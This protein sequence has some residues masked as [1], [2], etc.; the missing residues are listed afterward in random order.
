VTNPGFIYYRG[1]KYAGDPGLIPYLYRARS[2]AAAGVRMAAGSDAPVTPARPL[3]AIAA[4]IARL[5]V[6][7]YEL[8][9]QERIT[10]QDAFALFTSAAAIL[11]RIPA[12]DVA[13]GGLA[14]LI[15]LPADPLTLKPSELVDLSVDLTIVGGRIIYERGRPLAAQNPGASLFSA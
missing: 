3:H 6:E 8:A 2:L 4:A 12:G 7:G 10:A 5:S 11:A 14:D 9:L 15:V 13:P 1:L